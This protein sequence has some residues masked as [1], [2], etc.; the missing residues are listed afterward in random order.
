MQVTCL[1]P[2]SL[3][4]RSF[5]WVELPG[6]TEF[7]A[8]RVFSTVDVQPQCYTVKFLKLDTY[9]PVPIDSYFFVFRVS[10]NPSTSITPLIRQFWP[11]PTDVELEKFYWINWSENALHFRNNWL[12][13]SSGLYFRLS[14]KLL[15]PWSKWSSTELRWVFYSR[16]ATLVM[17]NPRAR[18]WTCYE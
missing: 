7:D 13:Y 1:S 3:S 14:K 18:S 12:H 11:N 2:A 16:A 10:V 8:R 17:N 6:A 15:C 9:R 5:D 4:T